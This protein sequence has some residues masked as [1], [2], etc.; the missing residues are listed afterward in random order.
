VPTLG[1]RHL[2]DQSIDYGIAIERLC[3]SLEAA[4]DAV[5]Q[6]VWS[7]CLHVFWRDKV[8]LIQP[9]VGAGA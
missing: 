4:N 3:I 7:D 9:R 8:T 1:Y 5:A 6:D 2:R